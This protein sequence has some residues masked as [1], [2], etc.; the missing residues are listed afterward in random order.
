MQCFNGSDFES[1][2]L[3]TQLQNLSTHFKSCVDQSAVSFKDVCDYL[4][5]LSKA[6][7]SF[8]SQVVVLVTLILVMPATKASSER[9]FSALRRIKSY[10]RSTMAQL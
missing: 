10:L 3:D 1:S 4:K 9:S 5:V 2:Q 7:Q 6:Q 8:Y